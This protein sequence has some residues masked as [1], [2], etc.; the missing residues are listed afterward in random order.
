[1]LF[2]SGFVSHRTASGKSFGSLKDYVEQ[3][4]DADKDEVTS[5][6]AISNPRQVEPATG[7]VEYRIGLAQLA[8]S[9]AKAATTVNSHLLPYTLLVPEIWV[10]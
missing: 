4:N 5:K 1:M 2:R 7:R 10:G 6:L 9:E 8:L 3:W